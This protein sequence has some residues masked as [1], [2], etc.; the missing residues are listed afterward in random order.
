MDT[1]SDRFQR[2][3]ISLMV[4]PEIDL[5]PSSL[6]DHH[7]D[8]GTPAFPYKTVLSNTFIAASENGVILSEGN[9]ALNMPWTCTVP[10]GR[11]TL[12]WD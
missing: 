2:P 5:L 7:S 8:H 4:S 3:S 1:S 12:T 10:G 6:Y 9:S 11:I